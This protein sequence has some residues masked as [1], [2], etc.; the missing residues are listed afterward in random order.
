[1]VG[2]FPLSRIDLPHAVIICVNLTPSE[3]LSPGD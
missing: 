1:M 3:C 2:Y